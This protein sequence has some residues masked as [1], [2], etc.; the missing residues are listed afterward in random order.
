MPYITCSDP[1]RIALLTLT[2]KDEPISMA[3]RSW[4]MVENPALSTTTRNNWTIMTSTQLEK[5]R[6]VLVSFLTDR[7]NQLK[8][9]MD[10]FDAVNLKDAKLFLNN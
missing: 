6:Y 8:K 7:K 9:R 5:P 10:K 3:F 2:E 1:A 4:E